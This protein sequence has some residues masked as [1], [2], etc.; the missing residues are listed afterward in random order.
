ML[1][2]HQGLLSAHSELLV[3]FREGDYLQ[4]VV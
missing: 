1:D 3:K 4:L 2:K